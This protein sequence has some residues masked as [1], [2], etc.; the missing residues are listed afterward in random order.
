MQELVTC[1]AN[2]GLHANEMSDKDCSMN[3]DKIVERK[4]SLADE[5]TGE[6]RE[7]RIEIGRPQWT[8]I[9]IEAVCPVFIHGLMDSALNIYGSDLLSALECALGFVK[10][11]LSNLPATQKVLWPDGEPYFD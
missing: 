6:Q 11:E 5:G 4:L 2:A 9:D 8:E 1:M 7:L 3:I 10:S